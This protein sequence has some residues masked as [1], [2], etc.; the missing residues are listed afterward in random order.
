MS[1]YNGC[2]TAC[3]KVCR[4][5]GGGKRGM[6]SRIREVSH[7]F[8]QCICRSSKKSRGRFIACPSQRI[9][10]TP[11][12]P[13]AL[14]CGYFIPPGLLVSG[15]SIVI[16]LPAIAMAVV[17]VPFLMVLIV[18]SMLMVIFAMVVVIVILSLVGTSTHVMWDNNFC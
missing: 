4:R 5:G 2:L 16:V 14:S 11:Y 7:V 13:N 12:I 6:N 1:H 3:Q 18:V 15:A 8:I 9:D 10:T 17:I